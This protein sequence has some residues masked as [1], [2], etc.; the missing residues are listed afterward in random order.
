MFIPVPCSPGEV[1]DKITVLEIKLEL[2]VDEAKL[3]H[4]REEYALLKKILEEKIHLSEEILTLKEELKRVNKSIWDSEDMVRAYWNDD[5][6]FLD[7]ARNS[8]A[9]NDERARVKR[10]I[11]VI[12]GSSIM[13]V[14]SHPNYE[15]QK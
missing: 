7:G 1:I 5:Q 12:L 9:M 6:K 13:E 15:R 10:S 4:V 2:I 14:K 11:N 8:H 3:A